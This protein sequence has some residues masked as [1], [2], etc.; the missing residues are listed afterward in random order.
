MPNSTSPSSLAQRL[1][2]R[3][4]ADTEA[5]QAAQQLDAN[6]DNLLFMG[7]WHDAIPRALIL[8]PSLQSTDTCVYLLLRTY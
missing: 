8:D 1:R 2:D 7:N 6:G 5:Q 3:I 4:L